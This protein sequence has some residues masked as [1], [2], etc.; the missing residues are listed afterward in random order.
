MYGWKRPTNETMIGR[1]LLLDLNHIDQYTLTKESLELV[2]KEFTEITEQ[3]QKAEI[4]FEQS[5]KQL[6]T[7]IKKHQ[8][9]IPNDKILTITNTKQCRLSKLPDV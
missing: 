9:L 1:L 3:V 7:L 2:D 6:K 8:S 4:C 5:H